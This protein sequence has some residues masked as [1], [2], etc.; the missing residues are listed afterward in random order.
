MTPA[1]PGYYR[2]EFVG[3]DPAKP[4]SV[5]FIGAVTEELPSLVSPAGIETLVVGDIVDSVN[6]VVTDLTDGV[7]EQADVMILLIHEGAAT[8]DISSV[9]DD[10][11]FGQIVAGVDVDGIV[12]AHTHLPYDH[13]VPIGP[14][15]QLGPVISTGQ[16]GERY[17]HMNLQIDPDTKEITLFDAEVLDLFDKFPADPIVAAIVADAVAVAIELGS[18]PLGNITADFNRAVVAAGTENRGGESTHRQLRRRRAALGRPGLGGAGSEGRRVPVLA[19]MNPGGL[20]T[21]LKYAVNPATPGDDVGLVT[22]SEAALVQP[23]ANT[24]IVEDVTGEQI[25]SGA[26]AAGS[27]RGLVGRS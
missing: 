20:R 2:Q 7:G 12:S 8:T 17:G 18:V 5:A 3:V 22:Y 4:V 26:R 23:F 19:L 27:V 21:D 16:Y 15:A 14:D 24:L 11:T 13:E 25:R 9:T 1:Y 10:S 6:R